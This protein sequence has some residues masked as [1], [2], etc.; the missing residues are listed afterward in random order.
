MRPEVHKYQ[1]LHF[2]TARNVYMYI[3]IVILA[4][5]KLWPSLKLNLT[6]LTEVEFDFFNSWGTFIYLS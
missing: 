3:V 5:L 6:S 4:Y 2:T 1:Y